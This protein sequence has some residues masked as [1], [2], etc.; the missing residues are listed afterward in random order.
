[1]GTFWQGFGGGGSAF[2]ERG[3]GRYAMSQP[4]SIDI[5]AVDRGLLQWRPVS[6]SIRASALRMGPLK[7]MKDRSNWDINIEF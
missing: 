4:T 3:H 7:Y 6:T 1:M 5:Q 2:G